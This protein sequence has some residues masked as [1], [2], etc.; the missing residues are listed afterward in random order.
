MTQSSVFEFD[1]FLHLCSNSSVKD[2]WS[3]L[4]SFIPCHYFLIQKTIVS[5]KNL[6]SDNIPI[7]VDVDI[8]I[9]STGIWNTLCYHPRFCNTGSGEIILHHI[10][11]RDILSFS[12]WVS[13]NTWRTGLVKNP[14][15]PFR[16]FKFFFNTFLSPPPKLYGRSFTLRFGDDNFVVP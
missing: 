1:L 16:H 14:F 13:T 9:V 3:N 12:S 7:L 5:Q 8:L 10:R 11:M 4:I 2:N 6:L 15:L